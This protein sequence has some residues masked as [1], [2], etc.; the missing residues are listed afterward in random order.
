[1]PPAS[2]RALPQGSL[3]RCYFEYCERHGFSA[4]ERP[5]VDRTLVGDP[6][7]A[8]AMAGLDEGL[9]PSSLLLFSFVLRNPIAAAHG[10][11]E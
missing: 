6:E 11:V 8:Y 1:M 9:L 5:E 2:L 3:G 7:L 10:S 4:D